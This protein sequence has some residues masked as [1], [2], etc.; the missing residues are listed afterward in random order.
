MGTTYAKAAKNY[1]VK[2]CPRCHGE[3][4]G[5]F[6]SGARWSCDYC[7]GAGKVSIYPP[8]PHAMAGYVSTMNE[9]G[10]TA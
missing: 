2:P 6:A 3:G 4:H 9:N 5:L 8:K 7:D 10:W 1:Q